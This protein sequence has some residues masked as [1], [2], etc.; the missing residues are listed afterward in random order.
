MRCKDVDRTEIR[1]LRSHLALGDLTRG[2]DLHHATPGESNTDTTDLDDLTVHESGA[3]GEIVGEHLRSINVSVSHVCLAS[4]KSVTDVLVGGLGDRPVSLPKLILAPRPVTVPQLGRCFVPVGSTDPDELVDEFL[5]RDIGHDAFV[6]SVVDVVDQ[7]AENKEGFAHRRDAP[8][9]LGGSVD[10]GD[11]EHQAV[12][13]PNIRATITIAAA[14][15]RAP[16]TASAG[17]HPPNEADIPAI[18]NPTRPATIDRPT[19]P[20][21]RSGSANSQPST[22]VPTATPTIHASSMRNPTKRAIA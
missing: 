4:A 5:P 17:G 3:L 20:K 21:R 13:G 14:P 10:I 19:V 16:K 12:S 9:R 18:P 8:E 11:D 15:A 1:E 7:I 2:V 22:Q 6:R